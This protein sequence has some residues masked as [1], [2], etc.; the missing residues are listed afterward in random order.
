VWV[1]GCVCG[2]EVLLTCCGDQMGGYVGVFC[3]GA[4]LGGSVLEIHNWTSPDHCT[5]SPLH[6]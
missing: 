5:T 4:L 3:C 1:F 6:H 2:G